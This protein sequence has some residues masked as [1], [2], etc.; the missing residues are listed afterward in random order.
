MG[1]EKVTARLKPLENHSATRPA[2]NPIGEYDFG[3]I[4]LRRFVNYRACSTSSKKRM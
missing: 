1:R 3:W 4:D 2:G